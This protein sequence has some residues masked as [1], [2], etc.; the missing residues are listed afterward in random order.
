MSTETGTG[1]GNTTGAKTRPDIGAGNIADTGGPRETGRT[2]RHETGGNQGVRGS[3]RH[4]WGQDWAWN[5]KPVGQ[6]INAS[7][8]KQQHRPLQCARRTAGVQCR[9]ASLASTTVALCV[10]H[11]ETSGA[12]TP[13]LEYLLP[14]ANHVRLEQG[15]QLEWPELFP[16]CGGLAQSPI[17]VVTSQTRHEPLLPPLRLV[18]HNRDVYEPFTLSN[19]GH[20]VKMALPSRMGVA[21]L[22]WQFSAFQLHLHWGNGAMDMATGSEHTIDGQSACAELHVVH[23]NSELYANVSEAK[24]QENGLAVLGVLIQ[25]GEEINQAY[26]NILHHLAYVRPH[27][28]VQGFHSISALNIDLLMMEMLVYS[29][30]AGEM[31]PTMLQN[32]YRSTQPLNHR[33][34]LSSFITGSVKRYTAGKI[35]AIVM[36]SVYGCVGLA[37]IICF[38]VKTVRTKDTTKDLIQDVALNTT[39]DPGTKEETMPQ[40]EP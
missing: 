16:E 15:G 34:V 38:I 30:K 28:T 10:C 33:V 29:S 7:M 9:L 36:G 5:M 40:S 19:N 13:N 25:S 17:D 22:P 27:D 32:N 2:G 23:Y 20:T 37:V 35:S 1:T 18:W 3:R 24:S 4:R 31:E 26:N 11:M 8:Y 14:R 21:G 39:P 6:E 12:V